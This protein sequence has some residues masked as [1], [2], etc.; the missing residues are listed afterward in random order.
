[1]RFQV[2]NNF[3]KW[4]R[5]SKICVEIKMQVIKLEVQNNKYTHIDD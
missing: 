1:M 5:V 3:H 2:V 4:I